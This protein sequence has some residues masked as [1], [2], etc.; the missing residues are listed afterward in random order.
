MAYSG[1]SYTL[2][3]ISLERYLN[4][5]TTN[6]TIWVCSYFKVDKIFQVLVTISILIDFNH[7]HHQSDQLGSFIFSWQAALS[8]CVMSAISNRTTS[9]IHLFLDTQNSAFF[10]SIFFFFQHQMWRG[11]GYIILVIVL[12]VLFNLHHFFEMTYDTIDQ[13]Y[14]NEGSGSEG[15]SEISHKEEIFLHPILIS[16][17]LTRESSCW[18]SGSLLYIVPTA[19]KMDPIYNNLSIGLNI[20]GGDYQLIENDDPV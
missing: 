9:F 18:S 13:T 5:S 6:E 12:A 19:L 17:C 1:I 15:W 8:T 3:A 16:F 2:M 4:I 10:S 20:M 14:C 7:M 11:W